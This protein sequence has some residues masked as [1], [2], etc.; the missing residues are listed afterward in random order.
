[1]ANDVTG[2]INNA[3]Y[4]VMCTML[5]L[6]EKN[7]TMPEL[8]ASISKLY[9]G[10]EFNN[11]VASKYVNT[12]KSCGFDIQKINGK[13][14]FV[15]FP[16]G[17]KFTDNEALLAY[18]LEEFSED[19]KPS[20]INKDVNSFFEK[21]HFI[22]GYKASNGLKSSINRRIMKLYEKARDAKCN[23]R[24]FYDDGKEEECFPKEV[25]VSDEGKI[26]LRTS[27][28]KGLQ[29]IDPD[30]IIDIKI[31]EK[32]NN[33]TEP[34]EEVVF[35]L[36]GKLARRYQLRENEQIVKIK[37]EDDIVISNKYEDKTHLLRRL[38]RYDSSC[39]LLKPKEYV[40]DF[41]DML[42][43]TLKNYADLDN[44]QENA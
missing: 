18:Q 3:S 9:P 37:K 26:L 20:Q 1:M 15:N 33:E 35:E 22:I 24:I 43:D 25:C 10:V 19:L 14:S 23:I 32:T 5:S 17:K 27:T 11:F 40:Q 28:Q 34:Y 42:N 8:I 41:K 39:K 30:N 38:M 21:L 12:C 29:E 7:L 36:K 2:K 6:F 44:T 16:V 31:T 4:G 13:Y